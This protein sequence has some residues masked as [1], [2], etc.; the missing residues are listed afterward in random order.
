MITIETLRAAGIL[1][2]LILRVVEIEQAERRAARREQ[3]RI[4]KQNQRSRQH[5]TAD[6]DDIADRRKKTVA[7]QTPRQQTKRDTALI[8]T[9]L[10]SS[11]LSSLVDRP[12]STAARARRPLPPDWEPKG[13]QRDATE[14]DEFRDHARAKGYQYIDWDAAYRNFQK[15][16]YNARNKGGQNGQGRRH[17]S[18][19]DAFDRLGERLRQA[20]ASEDYVPGS[21]GPRPL[22]LDQEMRAASLKLVP[23]R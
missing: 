20:G 16:P 19:L 13:E 11:S 10:P 7:D 4:N 15:S 23:K 9:S 2:A 17:G 6:S 21:S 5:V 8:L 14:A 22:Q 12:L 3:N 1:E 18:V